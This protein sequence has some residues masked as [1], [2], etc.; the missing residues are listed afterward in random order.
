VLT[1]WKYIRCMV[2]VRWLIW[3]KPRATRRRRRGTG[4]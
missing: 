1:H 3:A 2:S 4:R